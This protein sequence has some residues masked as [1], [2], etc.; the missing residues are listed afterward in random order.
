MDA[1][2]L[3][4]ATAQVGAEFGGDE[5]A[6]PVAGMDGA[7]APPSCGIAREVCRYLDPAWDC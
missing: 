5:G 6:E 3:E 2:V 4:P 1:P 7:V